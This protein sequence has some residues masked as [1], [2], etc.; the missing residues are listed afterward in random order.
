MRASRWP[1]LTGRGELQHVR[2]ETHQIPYPD[3]M[4]EALV[5]GARVHLQHG[6]ARCS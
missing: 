2:Q 1:S 5:C 6:S 3:A 4:L